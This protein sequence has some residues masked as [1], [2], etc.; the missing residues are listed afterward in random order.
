MANV[1][2]RSFG[3]LNTDTHVQD[4]RNGDYP[5]AKNIDHISAETGESVAVTPRM[6]NDYAFELGE[7]L[8]QDKRYLLT[9]PDVDVPGGYILQ[10]NRADQFNPLFEAFFVGSYDDNPAFPPGTQA[11]T[12]IQNAFYAGGYPVDVVPASTVYPT[13][14][15]T[16]TLLIS[17]Q[18][19]SPALR[20]YDYFIESIGQ[21]VLK[22]D[23]IQ[24]SISN[25]RTGLLEVIGSKDLLGDLFI[26]SSTRREESFE[27]KIINIYTLTVSGITT[28]IVI[29]D[30]TDQVIVD[31]QEVYITGVQGIREANGIFIIKVLTDPQTGETFILLFNSFAAQGQ[32]Y[33]P[34]TGTMTFN[35]F[36]IGEIGVAQKDLSKN[37]WKYTR[38]LRSKE[39]NLFTFHQCDV[40]G[41]KSFNRKSIYYTDNNDVP[42]NF[43]YKIDTEYYV[44]GGLRIL[45]PD[46]GLYDY[47]S[48]ADQTN[49]ILGQPILDIDFVSQAQGGGRLSSG[50]HVYFARGVLADGSY[51]D[52]SL[53]SRNIPVYS[54]SSLDNPKNIIGDIEGAVTDKANQIKISNVRGDIYSFIEV[55]CINY[56][57]IGFDATLYGIFTRRQVS[58]EDTEL[59]ITHNGREDVQT[60]NQDELNVQTETYTKAK[61]NAIIDNRYILSN[62]Q[63]PGDSLQ[64]L[65]DSVKYSL[66][67]KQISKPRYSLN[68]KFGG[69]QDPYNVF[70]FSGYMMNETYRIGARVRYKNGYISPVYN[71]FDVTINDDQSSLDGKRISGLSSYDLNALGTTGLNPVTGFPFPQD[72]NNIVPYIEIQGPDLSIE[73]IDGVPASLLLDRIEYFR[74]EVTNPS[75]IG[76]GFAV[77]HVKCLTNTTNYP[78]QYIRQASPTSIAT[79]TLSNPL[80]IAAQDNSSPIGNNPMISYEFPFVVSNDPSQNSPTTL[81]DIPEALNYYDNRFTINSGPRLG[82]NYG[83]KWND[84]YAS[85]YSI[86]SFLNGSTESV[87]VGAGD[88]IINTGQYS[89]FNTEASGDNPSNRFAELFSLN[90]QKEEVVIDN[91]LYVPIGD[92]LKI[93]T[94]YVTKLMGNTPSTTSNPTSTIEDATKL[95]NPGGD[96]WSLYGA[97]KKTTLEG[98]DVNGNNISIVG[99]NDDGT[100]RQFFG[101]GTDQYNGDQAGF[102]TWFNLYSTQGITVEAYGGLGLKF[103]A[104]TNDLY[105][106]NYYIFF[107]DRDNNIAYTKL[108]AP[109]SD[110]AN[111]RYSFNPGYVV[112][113]QNTLSSYAGANYKGR[114]TGIRAIQIKTNLSGINQYSESGLDKFVYTG[115]YQKTASTRTIDLFGGDT[116]TTQIYLKTIIQNENPTAPITG[117]YV[118]G[119]LLTTQTKSNPYLIYKVE[120]ESL[121]PVTYNASN[122]STN[123]FDWLNK[124]TFDNY[125][126]NTGYSIN[127]LGVGYKAGV[128]D[129]QTKKL[130]TRV[131]YSDNK[132]QNARSDFYRR[133][134][135]T[136]YNDLDASFGEINSMKNVNGEL[137]TLQVNKYQKQFFNSR[138]TLQVSDG[139]SVVLGDAGV[140]SRPGITVTSYGCSDKWSSFLGKSAGGDDILYWYDSIN[141]KFMRFGADGA[142]PI[143]DRANIRTLARDGFKWVIDYQTPADNYG[144]HGIWNQRLNEAAWTC[145][146]YRKPDVIWQ[147]LTA[148]SEG[149]LVITYD[150]TQSYGFERFPIIYICIQSSE[151]NNA[152]NPGED[153]GWEEYYTPVAF[154]DI[155]YYS[156]RT[157]VW[158]EIKNRFIISDETPHPRIYLQYKDT[159]LSP[160]PSANANE[161]YEHNEGKYLE[162]YIKARLGQREDGYIDIV[163]NID[164]NTTKHFISLIC[165]TEFMPYKV[166]LFTK[167]HSTVINPVEFLE[168]LDQY[169]APIPNDLDSNGS[170]GSDNSFLY[171]QWV[172]VRFHYESGKFQRLTN[173][174][175]KFNPMARLWNS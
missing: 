105:W 139:S 77:M 81:Y 170:T 54:A 135:I 90:T 117:G 61:N 137:F 174:I 121:F 14:A 59:I 151:F 30:A 9:Y 22:I 158:S 84:L 104:P 114:D 94:D 60:F 46:T 3:G 51:T 67:A 98:D 171:G 31:E 109:V 82:T 116:L 160:S 39:L 101:S 56:V 132:P 107:I 91:S 71:L 133:F 86:D 11:A 15:G 110:S 140:F 87:V 23:V 102:C 21:N 42:R 83:Y 13:L 100:Y 37:T 134:G 89:I 72:V 44:D 25:S 29:P 41:E 145:R 130:P 58:R 18:E 154:D 33:V 64:S 164:P 103:T 159:L 20:Y 161:L 55:A 129:E 45:Y 65:F 8:A 166:E 123:L 106:N 4:L 162:W 48:I 17:P 49:H 32:T 173:M 142:V 131:I 63:T 74:A 1:Q 122:I 96:Q 6:G 169:V 165:N 69:H 19:N 163:F 52:W 119:I 172:K 97:G 118:T 146:A 148:I 79:I 7:V 5:D 168:Q 47:G 147:P 2:I 57:D 16:R 144:I 126:Y 155:E 99:Y 115:S 152:L 127:D 125:Y 167:N 143:S 136:S 108:T 120:G 138:G 93:S 36:G 156:L 153:P 50:N 76:N 112:K 28:L 111:K 62:L 85:V 150:T 34:G 40:Q 113:L 68:Q 10:V 128:T 38:L 24:E 12:T 88:S 92:P 73:T 80:P 75:I 124:R 66:K 141:K 26:I 95:R 78:P 43:Y 70:Y 27:I 157:I 53:P 175:L 149:Q 35:K